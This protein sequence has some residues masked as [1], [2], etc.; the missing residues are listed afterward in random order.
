MLLL[1]IILAIVLY[2]LF[3]DF[4]CQY[5]VLLNNTP[6]GYVT[7]P[8]EYKE[9]VAKLEEDISNAYTDS[10][11]TLE[12]EPTFIKVYRNKTK[13][14]NLNIYTGTR[15]NLLVEYTVYSVTIGDFIVDFNTK[16]KATEY[17]QKIKTNKIT[18]EP[19]CSERIT[20]E[21]PKL[22]TAELVDSTYREIVSRYKPIIS[23]MERFLKATYKPTDGIFTSFFGY[24]EN[25]YPKLSY[26]IRYSQCSWNSSLCLGR[27]NSNFLW[28][29]WRLW[30]FNFNT[31]LRRFP[32]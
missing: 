28:V 23:P 1:L 4:C 17:I 8:N 27:R 32:K 5:E 10:K 19:I 9:V 26:W 12:Y 6:V 30:L 2:F 7:Q 3:Q 24:R 20:T 22:A 13:E 11:I 29:G 16:E 31:T 18:K 15:E 25:I 21:E 14:S